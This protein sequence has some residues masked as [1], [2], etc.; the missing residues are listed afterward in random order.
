MTRTLLALQLV[1]FLT[2]GATAGYAFDYYIKQEVAEAQ[3][4]ILISLPLP[5]LSQMEVS[6][7]I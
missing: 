2:F 7:D 5:A 3:A 6:R 4:S 1:F